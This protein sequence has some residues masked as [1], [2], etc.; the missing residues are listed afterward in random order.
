MEIISFF[1]FFCS[2]TFST[3]VCFFRCFFLCPWKCWKINDIESISW[4]MPEHVLTICQLIA[5]RK[6]IVWKQDY[7]LHWYHVPAFKST[8][9]SEQG[10][11]VHNKRSGIS[12]LLSGQPIQVKLFK[13]PVQIVHF[14][15][16]IVLKNKTNINFH[17]TFWNWPVN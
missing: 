5:I 4:K 2:L 9:S 7:F 8:P 15:A 1:L 12:V 10:T 16:A 3:C 13:I 6:W 17:S 14:W 11:N